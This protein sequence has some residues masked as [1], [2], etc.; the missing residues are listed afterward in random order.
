MFNNLR[1]TIKEL[2]AD[3]NNVANSEKAKSLRNKLI[4]IGLVL[5]IVGAIG[6]IVCFILFAVKGFDM[7]ASNFGSTASKMPTINEDGTISEMPSFSGFN[8]SAGLL[9]P[10]VLFIPFGAMTGIGIY[11]AR[12][13]FK[14]IVVGYT[15]GLIKETVGN[16]CPNCGAAVDQEMDFCSKCGAAVKKQ[17]S[18]C[19]Y[20]NDNK[21]DFCA[22]CGN[23]LD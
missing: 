11:L 9:I 17:C 8:F 6:T 22:K 5:A 2:N 1:N 14:I 16:N 13:G 12:L 3:V 7:V 19:N 20:Q 23:K 18:K 15:T 10:F 4:S 21:S